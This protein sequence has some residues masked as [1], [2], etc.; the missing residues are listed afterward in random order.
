MSIEPS[1]ITNDIA[2]SL[3]EAPQEPQEQSM[4]GSIKGFGKTP[5]GKAIRDFLW[6]SFWNGVLAAGLAASQYIADNETSLSA[7]FGA[8]GYAVIV[9]LLKAASL[10]IGKTGNK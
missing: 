6:F 8:V 2:P 10:Y 9:S 4:V 3:R 5:Q 7:T 1:A